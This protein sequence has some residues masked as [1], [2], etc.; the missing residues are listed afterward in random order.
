[1]KKNNFIKDST[2]EKTIIESIALKKKIFS[3]EKE[4]NK[5]INILYQAIKRG[6]K[7]RFNHH[8]EL[9]NHPLQSE[10]AYL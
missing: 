8:S 3:L 10:D 4:I 7:I 2:L 6:N 9:W 5:C 1:M